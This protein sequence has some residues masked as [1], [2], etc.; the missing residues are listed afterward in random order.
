MLA[1]ACALDA[2]AARASERVATVIACM[3]SW[4][5][6]PD[7]EFFIGLLKGYNQS[8]QHDMFDGLAAQL[9]ARNMCS[10]L[11]LDRII[12][13]NAA[14]RGDAKL[15][16]LMASLVVKSPKNIPSVVKALCSLGQAEYAAELVLPLKLPD[17]NIV[18]NVRL[19]LAIA[20]PVVAVQP[21]VNFL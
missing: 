2:D 7:P 21:S 6:S 15:A 14:R 20:D 12:M 13:T 3:R 16:M 8:H 1:A 19:Q 11:S 5:R 18:A 9:K 10:G 17:N 4:R